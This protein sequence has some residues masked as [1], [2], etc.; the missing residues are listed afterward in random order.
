M[1][2]SLRSLSLTLAFAVAACG[3]EA[4]PPRRTPPP[5]TPPAPLSFV[6]AT[7]S[8]PV[9]AII[10][11][12]N[13]KTKTEIANIKDQPVDCAIAKCSLDLVATR[14]GPITGHAADGRLTLVLP[15][16]ATA[17]LAMKTALFK[18]KANSLATG[19]VAAATALSLDRD[20]HLE[21][22]TQGRVALSQAQ[23]KLGPI[24]MSFA[25]LWNRNQDRLSGPLFKTLDRH[26]ASSIKIKPQAERLWLKVQRPIRVGKSPAAWLVLEP[27]RIRVMQ[28]ST[29]GDAMTLALGVDVRAQVIV[30]DRPP[31]VVPSRVLP[32]PVPFAAPSDRFSFVVP[33]FL[34]YGEAADL[35]MKR[36]AAQPLHIG[37][38]K[39]SFEKIDILPSGQDVVV[40]TRFC[41]TQS[42]DPFGWFDSC[43]EGYLRGQPAFDAASRT[44]RIV[45]VHYDIATEG[46]ILSV[47]RMLAGDQLGK[48]V[49]TKLVFSVGRDIDKLDAELRTALA[50]PQGR[51]VV[52]TGAVDSFGTPSLTWTRDGFLATFPASG[53]IHADLNLRGGKLDSE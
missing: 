48:A 40:A 22:D 3:F 38:D 24:K 41:V 43:G 26:V 7:L 9:Q 23:L 25:D 11:A 15:V 2:A 4:P 13:D 28:P 32:S 10:A 53:S 19:T 31:D 17:E 34:P 36:L 52:I 12:L 6:A 20:W 1:R 21:T 14:T 50:K 46:M 49:Q 35:A 42:W 39:V 37:A 8:V 18:T 33:V 5:P 16:A 47:M 29:R 45:N 44:I 30:S 27:Q 51:G